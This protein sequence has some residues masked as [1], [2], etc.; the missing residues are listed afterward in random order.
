ME[1]QTY[2]LHLKTPNLSDIPLKKKEGDELPLGRMPFS[3]LQ[4]GSYS[5]NIA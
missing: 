4:L 3:R 5:E 1:G 2:S